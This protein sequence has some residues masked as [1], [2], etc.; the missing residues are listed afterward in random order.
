MGKTQSRY[1]FLFSKNVPQRSEK[2]TYCVE[3]GLLTV[4]IPKETEGEIFTNL[5]SV[6]KL[7]RQNP[8]LEAAEEEKKETVEGTVYYGFN[9]HYSGVF[10]GLKAL[11]EDVIEVPDPEVLDSD[12]RRQM[13]T[14]AEETKFDGD[15]YLGDVFN[16]EDFQHV[17][18]FKVFFFFFFLLL[19]L[20]FFASRGGATKRRNL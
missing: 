2:A 18:D 6:T 8:L 11:E 5:D 9:N 16:V 4:R 14:L 19:L 20:L 12:A 10:K 17:I 7:V 3:S 1:A 15:Y 13:R